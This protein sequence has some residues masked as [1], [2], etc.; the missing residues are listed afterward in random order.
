MKEKKKRVSKCKDQ[1]IE[2]F[3]QFFV[4]WESHRAKVYRKLN[5]IPSVGEQR[6]M[7]NLWF[8]EIWAKI[9]QLSGIYQKSI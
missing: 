7:F 3:A 9:V 6:L 2:L 4:S 5:Q 1:L 8:W